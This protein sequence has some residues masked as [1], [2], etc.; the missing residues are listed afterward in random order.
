MLCTMSFIRMFCDDNGA[1]GSVDCDP[2]GVYD[3]C[4]GKHQQIY[5]TKIPGVF[6]FFALLYSGEGSA[7]V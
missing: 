3:S 5:N 4:N 2:K 1:F 7:P 6:H